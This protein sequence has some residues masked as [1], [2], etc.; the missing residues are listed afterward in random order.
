MLL[1]ILASFQADIIYMIQTK[2]PHHLSSMHFTCQPSYPFS[3]AT[4]ILSYLSLKLIHQKRNKILRH[5]KKK[6]HYFDTITEYAN[7]HRI[8]SWKHLYHHRY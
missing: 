2:L 8:W 1:L 3:D 5:T 7:V 6:L 4:I